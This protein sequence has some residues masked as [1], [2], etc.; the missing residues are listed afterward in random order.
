MKKKRVFTVELKIQILQEAVNS[1]LV[2]CRKH[3][4]SQSLFNRWKDHFI[5][6]GIDGLQ[7]QHFRVDVG[8]VNLRKR[9]HS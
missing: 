3:E 6:R 8:F 2:T 4:I 1:M 7:S 5:N 9:M